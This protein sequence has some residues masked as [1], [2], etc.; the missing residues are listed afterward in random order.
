MAYASQA[1]LEIA[2]GGAKKLLQLA[3]Y[4][5]TGDLNNANVQANIID[6]LEAEAATVRSKTEIKHEPETLASLDS[7]SLRKLRDVNAALS[8]R[9]AHEKG[10]GGMQMPPH[11]A[12]RAQRA[13]KFLEDLAAG[14]ARLGRA[15]NGTAAA[16]NQPAKVVDFDPRGSGISIA[17]FK[18]G[19]R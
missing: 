10:A 16:V 3:D 14:T 8:A 7:G 15:V 1:D 4:D 12:E 5:G 9:A 2:L 18:R 6:W 19:F 17:G 13:E 11:I